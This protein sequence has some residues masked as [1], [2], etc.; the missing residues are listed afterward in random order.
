M[1]LERLE[2]LERL[3]SIFHNIEAHWPPFDWTQSGPSTRAQDGER[4]RTMSLPFENLR[5]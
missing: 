5:P 1:G 3:E 2:L 4:S